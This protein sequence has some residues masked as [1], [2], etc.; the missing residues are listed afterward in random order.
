MFSIATL[1]HNMAAAGGF[2]VRVR[3]PSGMKR[4]AFGS[5]KEKFGAFQ[6][7]VITLLFVV[8]LCDIRP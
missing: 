8:M 2:I 4:F 6:A 5:D 3:A 1:S 7:Q